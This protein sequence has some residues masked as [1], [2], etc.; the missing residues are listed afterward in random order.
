MTDY[1]FEI[2]YR[3]TIEFGQADGLP[4]LIANQQTPMEETVKVSIS[5]SKNV[6]CILADS[7]RNI[8][9]T[10]AEIEHASMEDSVIRKS[11]KFV[12]TK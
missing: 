6:Y 7:I 5:L 1:D 12:K 9:V 8:L 10:V 11:M 4:R 3:E 2:K